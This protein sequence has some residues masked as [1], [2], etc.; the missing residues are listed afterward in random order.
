MLVLTRRR[1][2]SIIIAEGTPYET[3]ITIVRLA[4]DAVRIGFE[5]NKLVSIRREE[6]TLPS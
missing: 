2:E 4:S 3:K 1:D 5:S 6:I